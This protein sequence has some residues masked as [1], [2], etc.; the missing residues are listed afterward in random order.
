LQRQK[1][2]DFGVEVNSEV[3]S[4]HMLQKFKEFVI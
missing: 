2:S 4:F 3:Y 1:P